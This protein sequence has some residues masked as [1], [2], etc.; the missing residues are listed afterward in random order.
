NFPFQ[1]ESSRTNLRVIPSYRG[2]L[3]LS[4]YMSTMNSMKP[5]ST[6]LKGGKAVSS[7]TFSSVARKISE[8][9]HSAGDSVA[10]RHALRPVLSRLFP[11]DAY[12]VNTADPITR[13]VTGSVGDGLPPEKA[14]LLFKIEY[15]EP[16]YSKMVTLVD[17]KQNV[18]IL[19]E[20]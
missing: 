18:A 5:S 17:R 11:F 15:L 7:T 16:D 10:F 12:C 1:A 20:E 8:I 2:N 4:R 6:S 3:D 14:S 19:G 13:M 9:S